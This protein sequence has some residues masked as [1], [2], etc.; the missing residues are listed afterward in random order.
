MFKLL[1][2]YLPEADEMQ[3]VTNTTQTQDVQFNHPLTGDDI[4]EFQRLAR[5][6]PA[7]E[8][9]VRYAV[10]LASATRPQNENAPDF[11]KEWVSW[12][13]GLRA[14]QNLILAGKVRALLL[15]RY[16]VAYSDIQA[17]AEPI[18]RHRVLL[19][20]HAEAEKITVEQVIKKLIETVPVPTE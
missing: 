2:D 15:G 4:L 7:A 17:L 6:V 14:S 13:A 18:L 12:G 16:N 8:S 3:V 10:R 1:I 9:V 5:Q 19:N 20:F 11:I